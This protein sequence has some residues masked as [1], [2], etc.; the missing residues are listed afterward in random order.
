MTQLLLLPT[1]VYVAF[2]LIP[3]NGGCACV[4]ILW[5]IKCSEGEL[6][7]SSACD[8]QL[9]TAVNDLSPGKQ[10]SAAP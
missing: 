7:K 3:L 2:N 4:A 5:P 1:F 10:G 8:L 9:Q 6:M